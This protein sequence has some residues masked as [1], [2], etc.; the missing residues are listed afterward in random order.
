[1]SNKEGLENHLHVPNSMICT[2]QEAPPV[3]NPEDGITSRI[4]D[5]LNGRK[6]NTKVDTWEVLWPTLFPED[7]AIPDSRALPAPFAVSSPQFLS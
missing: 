1:M 3:Q 4:E 2:P 7:T 5:V 6:A